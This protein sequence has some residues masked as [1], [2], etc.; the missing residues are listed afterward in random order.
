ME[1]ANLP[2]GVFLRLPHPLKFRAV[3]FAIFGCL[4]FLHMAAEAVL[5]FTPE[6]LLGPSRSKIA[7]IYFS[8]VNFDTEKNLPTFFNF[9]LL[10]LS[11]VLLFLITA[12][13]YQRNDPLKIHWL[14]LAITF[15]LMSFDEAAQ[16]HEKL[17]SAVESALP[18]VGFFYYSWVIPVGIFAFLFGLSYISFLRR[19]P[20]AISKTIV[21]GGGLYILGALGMEIL[22]GSLVSADRS[23]E[24]SLGWRVVMTLEETFE[25][26]GIIFFISALIAYLRI[27]AALPEKP[28]VGH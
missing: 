20:L 12:I 18:T 19:L 3:A 8:V 11:A 13:V 25:M 4:L 27:E 28:L 6:Y 9:S 5:Y 26:S 14:I 15:L 1:R 22:A 17:G 23:A 24:L 16:M 10:V 2:F 7:G 21:L